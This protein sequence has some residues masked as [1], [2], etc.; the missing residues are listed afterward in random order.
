MFPLL[1]KMTLCM[2]HCA[3]T[4]VGPATHVAVRDKENVLSTHACTKMTRLLGYM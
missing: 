4:P 3:W 1:N 2:E